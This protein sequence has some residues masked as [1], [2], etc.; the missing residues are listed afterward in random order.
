MASH[1]AREPHD[2]GGPLAFHHERDQEPG[3]LRVR[4]LSR[5]DVLHECG[6]LV[7]RQILAAQE[8]VDNRSKSHRVSPAVHR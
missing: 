3:Q 5:H 8:R 2:L 7:G 1:R 4:H 6:R